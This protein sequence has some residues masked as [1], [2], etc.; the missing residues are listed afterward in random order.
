MVIP[1]S[2]LAMTDELSMVLAKS[3]GV[4]S[5]YKVNASLTLQAA[6]SV[7]LTGSD[8]TPWLGCFSFL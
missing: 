2:M 6:K 7:E 4:L 8:L 3:S 5:P 1:A